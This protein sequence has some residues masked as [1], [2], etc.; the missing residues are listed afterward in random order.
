MAG[1][2]MLAEIPLFARL[3]DEARATLAGL[4]RGESYPAGETIFS[5]GE[6]GDTMYVVRRGRVRI[7]IEN[8]WGERIV[9]AENGPGEI[10]GEVTLFEGGTRTAS[11]IAVDATQVYLL[12]RDDLLELVTRRPSSALAMLSVMGGRLRSTNE[13][14]MSRGSRTAGAGKGRRRLTEDTIGETAAAVW[15]SWIFA[16]AIAAAVGGWVAFGS[17]AAGAR[18]S[19]LAALGCG[20]VAIQ[21]LVAQRTLNRLEQRAAWKSE[22]D[23]QFHVKTDLELGKL[24][25][26]IEQVEP[27]SRA[28]TGNAEAVGGDLN[29]GPVAAKR[30]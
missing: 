14:L 24:R 20:L 7:V 4:L 11:A 5:V 22:R 6:R 29:A 30:N 10:F 15:G 2:R 17:E 3:D 8:D 9:L 25:A 28:A 26:L 21:I 12:D 16:V 18:G 19:W 27:S 13:L 23:D 1:D